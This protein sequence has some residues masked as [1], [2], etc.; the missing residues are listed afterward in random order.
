MNV[1]PSGGGAP[2]P[3]AVNEEPIAIAIVDPTLLDEGRSVDFDGSGSVDP[4]GAIEL[5]DWDFGDGSTAQGDVVTHVYSDDGTFTVTLT[6]TDDGTPTPATATDTATITVRN[7]A[8]TIV[9]VSA[10]PNTLSNSGGESTIAVEATDPAGDNDPLV[11]SFDCDGSGT[12]EIGPQADNSATCLFT[13]D[14]EGP[15]TVNVEVDDQDGGVTSRSTTVTVSPPPENV[16]PSAVA[17]G[18]QTVDEGATVLADGTLSTDED[19]NTIVGYEW[20]F[21]DGTTA[22]GSTQTHAYGD[23]GTFTVTLTVTDDDEAT[24]TDTLTVNNVAPRV[25]AGDNR[26][27]DEGSFMPLEASFDDAG[28]QDTFSAVIDWGDG[29]S[30]PISPALSPIGDGHVYE[31]NGVFTVTVTDDDG[32]VGSDTLA[33]FVDNVAPTVDAGADQAAFV[34]EPVD[35]DGSFR[36]PGGDDTHT[37]EWDFGD[38]SLGFGLQPTHTYEPGTFTATLTVTDDDGASDSDDAQVI[39]LSEATI[40]AG[41]VASD[42]SV[43]DDDP[44]AGD[45]V[46][47]RFRVTNTGNQTVV[48]DVELLVNGAV[49]P[50]FPVELGGQASR[51]LRTPTDNPIIGTEAGVIAVQVADQLATITIDPANIV[52]S[53]L[54]TTPKTVG[55][56][57]DV[58]IRLVITNDGAVAGPYSVNISVDGDTDLRTGVL[59]PGQSVREFRRVPIDLPLAGIDVVGPPHPYR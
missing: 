36:D 39:V 17:I 4:D 20:D 54:T 22:E 30:T 33:V 15:N 29:S 14:D 47:A 8:P 32:G 24:D 34:G 48:G 26:S 50:T 57:S 40:A 31:D 38:G 35:F 56:G 25:D 53:N 59:T 3:A 11:Y 12:F 9:R 55:V 10:D 52:I 58:E 21:G 46:S 1:A 28:L 45:P 23:D 7:V 2:P 19:S 51:T 5:Y 41:L 43:S 44:I 27:V 6:V 16:P 18:P 49:H 42:L 13:E 37:F